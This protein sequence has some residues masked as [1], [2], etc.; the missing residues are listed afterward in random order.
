MRER[1][2]V[3]MTKKKLFEKADNYKREIEGKALKRTD[4]NIEESNCLKINFVY[5]NI[6]LE[7]IQL[8]RAE[9]ELLLRKEMEKISD[10]VK[11]EAPLIWGMSQA[12][13]VI[14]KE[15]VKKEREVS[16]EDIKQLHFLLYHREYEKEAGVYRTGSKNI[17]MSEQMAPDSKEI[18]HLMKH[19]INQMITS[20]KMFHPI[21]YAAICHKRIIDIQPFRRGNEMVARL[22]MNF[23]L[24]QEGYEITTISFYRR[25]EYI[26]AL[27]A[28]RETINPQVDDLVGIIAESVIEAQEQILGE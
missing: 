21:E 5:N 27:L 6:G 14:K 7:G 11:E 10:E 23:I 24:I 18:S 17:L 19:F 26:K 28:S 4:L 20:K 1:K 13:D 12:Y 25:K 22:F 8:T 9:V 3:I 16:E 2:G 15:A